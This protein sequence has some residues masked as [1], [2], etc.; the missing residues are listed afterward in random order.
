MLLG[1]GGH[2]GQGRQGVLPLLRR[3]L[4]LLGLR[5]RRLLL[6]RSVAAGRLLGAFPEGA[7]AN[8]RGTLSSLPPVRSSPR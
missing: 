1:E 3:R 6:K 2:T 4:H 7:M 5:L 8:R